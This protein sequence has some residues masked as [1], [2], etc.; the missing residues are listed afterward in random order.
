MSF[1]EVTAARADTVDVLRK[2]GLLGTWTS[3]CSDHGISDRMV[4][5]RFT[6][7]SLGLAKI[8]I[9][10]PDE[11]MYSSTIESAVEVGPEQV[12][13]VVFGGL[14][15]P[16]QKLMLMVDAE[17]LEVSQAGVGAGMPVLHRCVSE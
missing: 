5:V 3:A 7:S 16:D 1:L 13:I 9:G 17:G 11:I 14:D 15:A 10:H 4:L 6:M 2:F 12:E 8:I